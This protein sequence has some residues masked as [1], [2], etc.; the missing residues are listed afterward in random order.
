MLFR[1]NPLR[2]D[3]LSV[4]AFTLNLQFIVDVHVPWF[5]F[6]SKSIDLKIVHLGQKM[7]YFDPFLD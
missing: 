5:N 3:N 4:K 6:H 7:P 1:K 2:E